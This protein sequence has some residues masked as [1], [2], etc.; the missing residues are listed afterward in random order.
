MQYTTAQREAIACLD[1]PLLIVACAGSGKTQ[2]LSSRIV[3]LLRRPDVH[4]RN[5]V[6][7]TFTDKAAAELKD[8]TTTL[9]EKEFGQVHG[10]AEMFVG[11]MHAYALDVLH[12]WVAET[13]KYGVL[14]EIQNRLLVDRISRKCGLATTVATVQGTPRPL[15][16][17]TE[18]R[19]FL[20]VM[21]IL[22]EDEVDETLLPESLLEAKDMYRR[23][24]VGKVR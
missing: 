23:Q 7:F 15:R 3:E 24:G 10:L 12:S 5:I 14:N 16:R 8:R 22:R 6:A 2:V 13:F 19:L 11:T 18:S 4:P 1:E 21:N 9:V 17:Y 20:Q